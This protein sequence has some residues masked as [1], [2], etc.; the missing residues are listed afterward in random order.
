MKQSFPSD[1]NSYSHRNVLLGLGQRVKGVCRS[2]FLALIQ[3]YL[4]ISKVN[5]PMPGTVKTGLSAGGSLCDPSAFRIGCIAQGGPKSFVIITCL[6][7]NLCPGA[8]LF[9]GVFLVGVAKLYPVASRTS[10]RWPDVDETIVYVSGTCLFFRIDFRFRGEER[11]RLDDAPMRPNITHCISIPSHGRCGCG[12]DSV[13]FY[14]RHSCLGGW[15]PCAVA[16]TVDQDYRQHEAEL[17]IPQSKIYS[18]PC[19][20]A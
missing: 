19:L 9:L 15:R 16:L 7:L 10:E 17:A 4:I 1:L 2:R 6:F 11:I 14:L 13:Y 8:L 12:G 20:S 3:S 18:I 5:T